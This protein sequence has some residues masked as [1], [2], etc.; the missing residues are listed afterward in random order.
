MGVGGRQPASAR[1]PASRE[2]GAL[3][4]D[5]GAARMTRMRRFIGRSW[6]LVG[7]AIVAT[8]AFAPLEAAESARRWLLAA[9]AASMVGGILWLNLWPDR[10]A[11]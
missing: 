6:V 5:G 10:R 11:A 2:V 8:F 1:R 3:L 9:G 4:P 7:L